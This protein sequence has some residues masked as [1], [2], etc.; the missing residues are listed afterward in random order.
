MNNGELVEPQALE[1]KSLIWRSKGGFLALSAIILV[2][3]QWSKWLVRAHLPEHVPMPVIPGFLNLTH[4][5]NPGVAFG[6]FAETGRSGG[7]W[8]L[9]LLGLAALSMVAFYFWKIP[10]EQRLLQTALALVLGGAVGNLIDRASAGEVTDFVDAYFGTYHWHTFNV[11]DSAITV[12][13]VF[14]AIDTLLS[15]RRSPAQESKPAIA[16]TSE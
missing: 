11:A 4:V 7:S 15:L 10:R 6:F 5:K 14:I 9:T 8:L 3:D 12:G 16:E 2:L 1:S 13:I